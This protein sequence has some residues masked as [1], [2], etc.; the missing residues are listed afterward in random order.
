MNKKFTIEVS[1]KDKKLL[2][3]LAAVLIVVGAYY[4]GYQKFSAMTTQYQTEAA[5][6]R[7]QQRDLQEKQQNRDRYVAQ[8]TEYKNQ[9][10]AV[11][12]SYDSGTTQDGT[13][14]FLSRVE[15]ITG[16]WIKSTTF[17]DTTN[18]YTFGNVTS[19]N[20]ISQGNKVYA[21]DM[22]GFKTTIT[23]TYE[24]SYS[25]LLELIRYINEYYSKNTIDSISMSYNADTDTVTGNMTVSMYA[26][27]GTDRNFL[28]PIFSLPT[29]TMNI[30]DSST[31]DASAV[32]LEDNNGDYILGDY[33]YFMMLSSAGADVDSCMIGQRNDTSQSSVI[34]GN[35]TEA[36]NVSVR[37]FGTAGAYRAQYRIG[38]VTYPAADY[39]AGGS[40]TAG[41]TLD[42]LILSS[43][44]TDSKDTAVVNLSVINDTDMPLNIKLTND[45]TKSSR[46]N[47]VSQTGNITLYQ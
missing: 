24:A 7:T 30:F 37:F 2:L 44:R 15:R 26:V 34:S 28:A 1:E 22:Q 41:A 21:T 32:D 8:T 29:G 16:S 38:D 43:P 9:Y 13:L 42:M 23:L 5:K 10:Q 3:I 12:A 20:P 45:D 18:I 6:L 33:D 40:F 27:T 47:F 25:E 39:N 19:S 4:F 14:D 46:V 36:Q 31:F 35:S 17:A 11:F